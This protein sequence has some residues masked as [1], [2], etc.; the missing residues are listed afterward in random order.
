MMTV[1]KKPKRTDAEKKAAKALYDKN[2]RALLKKELAFKRKAYYATIKDT[3]EYK[4][5]AKVRRDSLKEVHAAYVKT[6]RYKEWKQDYDEKF[7]A[8]KFYGKY[9]ECMLLVKKIEKLVLEKVPSKYQRNIMRGQID[10]M[11]AKMYIKKGWK[12]PWHNLLY[13]RYKE[14]GV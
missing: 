3:P 1:L 7:R 9:W 5:K 14:G 10:R 8:K 4:A 11:I 13:L 6:P 2:R 12:K